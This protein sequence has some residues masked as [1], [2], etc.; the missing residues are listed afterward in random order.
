MQQPVAFTHLVWFS[1]SGAI[2]FFSDSS[3]PSEVST[4]EDIVAE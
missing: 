1:F 3:T 2:E 4:S